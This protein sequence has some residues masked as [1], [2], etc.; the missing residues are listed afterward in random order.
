MTQQAPRPPGQTPEDLERL[1]RKGQEIERKPYQKSG[2]EDGPN[3][4]PELP[5]SDSARPGSTM[6]VGRSGAQ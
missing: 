1:A 2:Q 5:G 3:L 4:D 6:G